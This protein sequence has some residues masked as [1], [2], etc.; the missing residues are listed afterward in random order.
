MARPGLSGRPALRQ[1]ESGEMHI[2]S[3][4]DPGSRA[5]AVRERPLVR[6]PTTLFGLC[7][8][9]LALAT[10][11]STDHEARRIDR[12]PLE[13]FAE[14][15]TLVEIAGIT[16]S[17]IRLEK[18]SL[19]AFRLRV[20]P[21]ASGRLEFFVGAK[22][23]E[24]DGFLEFTLSDGDTFSKSC[25]LHWDGS[26]A[27]E[28]WRRCTIEIERPEARELTLS[29]SK[30]GLRA[31]ETLFADPFLV[32]STLR[33]QPDVFVLLADTMRAD[34]LKLFGGAL[35]IDR[36]MERLARNAIVFRKARAPSSWTRTSVATL[37]TGLL[38][39]SHRVFGRL[40]RLP[41][42]VDT[43]AELLRAQ[44]Y[45][46]HAW[47][48]NPN[49]LPVFG[50]AQGFDVFTD[51]GTDTWTTAKAEASRLVDLLIEEVERNERVP[52]LY[53]VHFMD[54]HAP[55]QP[56]ESQLEALGRIPSVPDSFP[57]S[58]LKKPDEYD[59]YR[60]YLAEI[61]DL[62]EQLGRFLDFL[63]RSGRY[64]ESLV[65]FVS[66]HGEEFLDH[67]DLGHGKTLFEEMLW[68]PAILKPPGLE[69]AEMISR[70]VGL[71]DVM[72][73][74]LTLLDVG[75]PEEIEGHDVIRTGRP[76][77]PIPHVATLR[78][79]HRIQ[80]AVIL[81][82]WK[83]IFYHYTGKKKLFDLSSDPH[84]L[85]DLSE[86]HPMRT[87]DLLRILESRRAAPA[88][89]WHLRIC[90]TQRRASLRLQ[91]IDSPGVHPFL[92]ETNDEIRK[93]ESL[94]GYDVELA[95][96]PKRRPRSYFGEIVD[97]T[98]RD[99][100]EILV[101]VTSD[102]QE[103]T[104]IQI[105]NERPTHARFGAAPDPHEIR[106]LDLA[107][108]RDLATVERTAV[109]ECPNDGEEDPSLL[110]W[111]VPERDRME[112]ADLPPGT[113]ERLRALGYAW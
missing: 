14:P 79:D 101:E 102:P 63:E 100:D 103:P 98:I 64:E 37:L 42:D 25:L 92:F 11:C 21:R 40:D 66:D 53:Y 18:G 5:N 94:S 70:A 8:L 33:H 56:G 43:L 36:S 48:S 52:G 105:P 88:A 35:P 31:S 69:P 68:V 6:S 75:I 86:R 58:P 109:V 90:G 24:G 23:I 67:G 78:L 15:P 81:G 77:R 95:L 85:N 104:R 17:A 96:D 16:R 44:G 20:E 89:G 60:R 83:L 71:Q 19:T 27:K 108:I 57:L 9:V 29:V 61:L 26:E 55:Y 41:D 46:T 51:V 111:F 87:A 54:P 7:L 30:S 12:L 28:A 65:V 50:F 93:D 1:N 106:T 4:T 38:P 84:E 97:V 82:N 110:V 112:E 32:P 47:S 22:G 62:D 13:G 80:S 76:E 2:P 74:I 59:S 34:R 45:R 72:P 113:R 73:S 3:P 10:A 99:E 49:I 91:I 107:A 39:E